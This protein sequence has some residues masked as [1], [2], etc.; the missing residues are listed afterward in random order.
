MAAN[1]FT[2]A[3]EALDVALAC[4]SQCLFSNGKT[5]ARVMMLSMARLFSVSRPGK[6][7]VI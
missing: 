5:L 6:E 2:R 7:W 1:R 4:F 3:P